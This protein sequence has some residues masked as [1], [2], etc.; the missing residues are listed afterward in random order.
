EQ[1]IGLVVRT[2]REVKVGGAEASLIVTEAQCPKPVDDERALLVLTEHTLV[3]CDDVVLLL[4]ERV[5]VDVSVAEVSDEQVAG[6]GPEAFR[7][8]RNSPRRIEVA[9]RD[10]ALEQ[11]TLGAVDVDEAVTAPGD[12]VMLLVVLEGIRDEEETSDL[13]DVERRKSARKLVVDEL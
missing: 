13:L 10:E 6:E 4:F 12:V 3:M 1:A 2:R 8:E 11:L 5:D 7:R 9:A